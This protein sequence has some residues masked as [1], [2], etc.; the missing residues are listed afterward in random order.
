VPWREWVSFVW[1]LLLSSR[2]PRVYMASSA[3][4]IE[5]VVIVKR[6]TLVI[7]EN[8]ESSSSPEAQTRSRGQ[9]V[10]ERKRGVMSERR[11]GG[12]GLLG[13]SARFCTLI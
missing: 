7:L 3:V 4:Y 9:R 10:R 6:I 12:V 13:I 11:L 8:D 2:R 1:L 5:E